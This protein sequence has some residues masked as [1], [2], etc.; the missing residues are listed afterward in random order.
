MIWLKG[1]FSALIS[2][3][4]SAIVLMVV[5]PSDFNFQDTTKILTV[6]IVSGIISM[7]NYLKQSPLP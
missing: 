3:V 6:A 5:N 4:A 1:L 2:G 7:A